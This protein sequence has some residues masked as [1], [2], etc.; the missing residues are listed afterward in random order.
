MNRTKGVEMTVLQVRG[1]QIHKYY[2]AAEGQTVL[3]DRVREV[4]RAAPFFSPQTP[5]GRRMRCL[6]YTSDAADE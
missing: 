4:V 1:A 2:L 3:V 5:Y 6:L